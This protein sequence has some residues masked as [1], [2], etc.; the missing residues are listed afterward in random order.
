MV[1]TDFAKLIEHSRQHIGIIERIEAAI[2]IQELSWRKFAI[3]LFVIGPAQQIH[4]KSKVA[5]RIPY[6][7]NN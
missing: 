1:G 2:N 3:D 7:L 5:E 6:T 4:V